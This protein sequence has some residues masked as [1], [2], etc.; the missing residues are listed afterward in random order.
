MSCG[1]ISHSYEVTS[2]ECMKPQISPK[3]EK[4][5]AYEGGAV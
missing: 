3:N 1:K 4:S 5:P 2:K